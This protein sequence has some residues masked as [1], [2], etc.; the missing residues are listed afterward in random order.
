MITNGTIIQIVDIDFDGYQG[1]NLHP[2][3]KDE[4]KCGVIFG[5]HIF[6]NQDNEG[7]DCIYTI[8]LMDEDR[9]LQVVDSEIKTFDII[10]SQN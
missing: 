5:H 9:K 8:Q 10:Y 1:R 4:G 2:L 3:K 6:H 7:N